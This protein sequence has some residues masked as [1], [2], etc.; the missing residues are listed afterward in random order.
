MKILKHLVNPVQ[1]FYLLGVFTEITFEYAELP[2][3]L[4]ALTRY[5]YHVLFASP[6]FGNVVTFT[7]TCAICAKLEQLFP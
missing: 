1:R 4:N 7:P 3:A 5:R 6:E 2:D